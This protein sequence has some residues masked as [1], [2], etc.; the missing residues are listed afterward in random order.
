MARSILIMGF[1]LFSLMVSYIVMTEPLAVCD[2]S[3]LPL[4]EEG[5]T[6][7][8]AHIVSEGA[9][10]RFWIFN[11]NSFSINVTVNGV[12]IPSV[13]PESGIDYDV[14]A[15]QISTPYEQV[16]YK[17]VF[18]FGGYGALTADYTVL[19]LNSNFVQ[20]F[21]LIFPILIVIVFVIIATVAIVILRRRIHRRRSNLKS[22]TVTED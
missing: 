15:P 1:V 12:D 6:L 16:T 2:P 18:T 19:V 13:P 9:Y 10:F 3:P 4:K 11:N 20:I 8:G 7:E 5:V 14:I 22:G 21:D 17:F